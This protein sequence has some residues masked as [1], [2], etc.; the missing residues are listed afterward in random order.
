MLY[1]AHLVL[2]LHLLGISGGTLP[3]AG[4]P[5]QVEPG[6]YVK[7]IQEGDLQRTYILRVPRQYDNKTKLPLVLL[8]HGWESSAASAERYTGFGAKCEDAG[9]ILAIPD[10]T[11]GRGSKK[12]WNTGFANL[13]VKGADDIQLASDILDQVEH[14]L[15]VDDNRVYVVGH[16]NGAMMTY[17]V[18][19]H[20]SERIAAIGIVSGTVGE[21]GK[22]IPEPK[23]PVS[24]IIFHGKA[25]PTVPYDHST[26]GIMVAV[27]AP[28]SAKW[29]A[30]Q[31]GCGPA[32]ETTKGDGNV[33]IDDYK[34]GKNGTEVEFV[35]IVNGLH[36]WPSG[37]TPHGPETITHVPATDMIWDFLMSHP[38]RSGN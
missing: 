33:I 22:H 9:F 1:F 23:V 7:T 19:A 10:G 24:A 8:F 18:A 6:R 15:L 32:E 2:S 11:E 20:L 31:D 36:W 25:D 38:R 3:A 35:T 29:W 21:P 26:T 30:D 28:E 16:S 13:G 27:P 4:V 5:H 34:N 37:G 17:S 14:D 12:G